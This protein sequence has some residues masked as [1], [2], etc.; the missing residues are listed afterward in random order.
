M[1]VALDPTR[2][3][4]TLPRYLMMSCRNRCD[5]YMRKARQLVPQ[6]VLFGK[7]IVYKRT[8]CDKIFSISLLHGAVSTDFPSLLN[9]GDAFFRHACE[10]STSLFWCSVR[11]KH[12]EFLMALDDDDVP[13]SYLLYIVAV[14]VVIGLFVVGAF[15][16]VF[17]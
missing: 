6:T 2:M 16:F 1:L 4:T 15:V 17:R 14:V 9:I 10:E 8:V 13:A 3:S 5:S 7:V 11:S 12:L